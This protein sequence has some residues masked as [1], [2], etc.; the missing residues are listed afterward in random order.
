LLVD[1]A[2]LLVYLFLKDRVEGFLFLVLS[3]QFVQLLLVLSFG[4]FSKNG[5]V[6][7]DLSQS[8]GIIPI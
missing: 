8:R 3:P 7:F 2:V 1:L 4:G 5:V 6:P